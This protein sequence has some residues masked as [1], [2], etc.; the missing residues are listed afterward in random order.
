V[1]LAKARPRA[2]MPSP[3]R[4]RRWRVAAG[5][6]PAG[7]IARG[8]ARA[9]LG[10]AGAASDLASALREA[11]ALGRRPL[12]T[13]PRKGWPPRSWLGPAAEAGEIVAARAGVGGRMWLE[14]G[15]F[16]LH[17][18]R[19]VASSWEDRRGASLIE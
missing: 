11:D 4:K 7:G 17:A 1:A 3:A 10:D 5:R 8:S 18:L 9:T 13:A 15:L 2:P 12:R 14:A 16:K 19:G 6:H